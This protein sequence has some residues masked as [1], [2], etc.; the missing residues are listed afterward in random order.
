MLEAESVDYYP[1]ITA[2]G[3]IG[4][5]LI[6]NIGTKP[7]LHGYWLRQGQEQTQSYVLV[8]I[9]TYFVLFN[10]SDAT[11]FCLIVFNLQGTCFSLSSHL[12]HFS[13]LLGL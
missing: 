1:G 7:H 10:L 8:D 9:K 3:V 5:Q 2:T 11:G 6:Y 12:L 4:A 13:I